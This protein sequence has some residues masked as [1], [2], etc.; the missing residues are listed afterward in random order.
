MTSARQGYFKN[1]REIEGVVRN[2]NK[3]DVGKLAAWTSASHI[4]KPPKKNGEPNTIKTC[5]EKYM[6]EI[7]PIQ[8]RY[9]GCHFRSRTEAKWAVFFDSIGFKWQY[10]P[11]GYGDGKEAYLPDFF[12]TLPDG[13]E[14]LADVKPN[15]Y[16]ISDDGKE[17]FYRNLTSQLNLRIVLLT[18]IPEYMAYDSIVPQSKKNS[19]QAVFFQDYDPFLRIADEYWL[20]QLEFDENNGHMY[21]PHDD[22]AAEKS[23][24]NKYVEAI[25]AARSAR[26]EFG[27]SEAT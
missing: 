16:H 7:K 26:F 25:H 14:F 1:E 8:T 5:E 9:K 18:G 3:N 20:A 6:Y 2:V 17:E 13:A 11:E 4:E 15:N 23:F 21:F 12:V 24:G 10:E 19:L 22:R 27:E